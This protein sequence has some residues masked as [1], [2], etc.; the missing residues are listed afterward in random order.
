MEV[1]HD[2][3]CCAKEGAKGKA[4]RYARI[5][6]VV[7]RGPREGIGISS[8]IVMTSGMAMSTLQSSSEGRSGGA[9][10]VAHLNLLLTLGWH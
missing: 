7:D 1:H 10:V 3:L 5:I 4:L 6:K 8:G 2:V 9:T